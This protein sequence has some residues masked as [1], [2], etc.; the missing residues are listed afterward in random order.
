MKM[1]KNLGLSGMFIM[2]LATNLH[3]MEHRK[4]QLQANDGTMFNIS[5]EVAD[6]SAEL[7]GDLKSIAE[8]SR[9]FSEINAPIVLR[10]IQW[11][12]SWRYS[13]TYECC[14]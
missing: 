8:L 5:E 7:L 4:L 14:P 10:N 12:S 9:D 3:A 1:L 2:L 11:S 6:L 13:Q